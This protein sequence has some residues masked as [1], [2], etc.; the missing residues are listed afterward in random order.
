M[1]DPTIHTVSALF[2][3]EAPGVLIDCR[4]LPDPQG[5]GVGPDGRESAAAEGCVD[6]P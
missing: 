1:S 2:G 5:L 3:Q 6:V 4:S